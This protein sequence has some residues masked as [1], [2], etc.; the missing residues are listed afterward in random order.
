M[1]SPETFIESERC[2]SGL[3]VSENK[4]VDDINRPGVMESRSQSSLNR[5]LTS[6]P[7]LLKALNQA[8]LEMLE[9]VSVTRLQPKGVLSIDDSLLTHYGRD[10]DNIAKLFDPA[11]Q[12]YVL[13]H[14]PGTL[15]YSDDIT[16][17]PLLFQL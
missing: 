4:T 2:I 7:F 17:F 8:R 16:G 12:S 11:S 14:D 13:A 6:G 1:F 10:F 5:L 15:H 3:I 9:S